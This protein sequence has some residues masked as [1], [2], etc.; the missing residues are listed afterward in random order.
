MSTA[1]CVR[2]YFPEARA[3]LLKHGMK[4]AHPYVSANYDGGNVSNVGI[5]QIV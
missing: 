4:N 5:S 2:S 1:R 3:Q